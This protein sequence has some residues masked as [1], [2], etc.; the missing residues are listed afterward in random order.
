MHKILKTWITN[1]LDYY[2][3][4]PRENAEN[5]LRVI[6]KAGMMPPIIEKESWKTLPNGEMT[7][8]VHQWEK[9]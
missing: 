7:Y 6:E 2:N 5:L 1:N 9:E 3:E 8:A 4:F